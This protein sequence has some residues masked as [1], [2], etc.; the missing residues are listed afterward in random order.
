[1]K[2]TV[3]D[4]NDDYHKYFDI[5]FYTKYI[6]YKMLFYKAYVAIINGIN[7]IGRILL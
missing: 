3:Y 2:I 5:L 1:M 4:T 6:S 7:V